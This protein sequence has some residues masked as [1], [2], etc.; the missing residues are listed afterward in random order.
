MTNVWPVGPGGPGGRRGIA[1][2]ASFPSTSR[3]RR[4]LVG[5]VKAV[6]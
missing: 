5:H 4:L 1:G 2:S 3:R 6:A